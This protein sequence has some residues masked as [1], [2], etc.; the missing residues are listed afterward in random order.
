MPWL[1][2]RERYGDRYPIPAGCFSSTLEYRGQ[3]DVDDAM[4]AQ[5]AANLMTFL[6]AIGAVKGWNE[7]P[8]HADAVHLPFDHAGLSSQLAE[9]GRDSLLLHSAAPD[10]QC[11]PT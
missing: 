3:F 10:R 1:H 11:R 2:L 5:D 9:R 6:S 8:A 7:K 4:A